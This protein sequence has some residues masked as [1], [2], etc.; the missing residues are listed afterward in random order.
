MNRENIGSICEFNLMRERLRPFPFRLRS[1]VNI[2]RE[3]WLHS[4]I[5]ETKDFRWS[6]LKN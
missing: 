1:N 2:E 6:I 3:G 5:D 4:Y